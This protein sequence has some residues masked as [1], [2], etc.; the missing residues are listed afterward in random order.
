VS[1]EHI[2][3]RLDRLDGDGIYEGHA[4][5]VALADALAV[6]V[7]VGLALACGLAHGVAVL[8]PV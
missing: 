7:A 8:P 4:V 1:L 2:A 6:G 5:G 3:L